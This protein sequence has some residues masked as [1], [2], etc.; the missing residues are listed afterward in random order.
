MEKSE[1]ESCG[2][3][4]VAQSALDPA[5]LSVSSMQN[6]RLVALLIIIVGCSRGCKREKTF[7][8]EPA[9]PARHYV[10]NISAS[11]WLWQWGAAPRV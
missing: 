5:K 9:A 10:H 4:T 11:Y 1:T 2:S 8:A 6:N 7:F 3:K